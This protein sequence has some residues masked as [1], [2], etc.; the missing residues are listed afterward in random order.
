MQE[1]YLTFAWK[2]G[3]KLARRIKTIIRNNRAH[4]GDSRGSYPSRMR[5]QPGYIPVRT[6]DAERHLRLR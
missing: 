2:L 1:N 6:N 3:R 4:L 5:P